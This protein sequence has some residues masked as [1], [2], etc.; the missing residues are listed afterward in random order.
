MAREVPP[1]GKWVAVT[2]SLR[3]KDV[4]RLD[5]VRGDLNRSQWGRGVILAA[6]E[7]PAQAALAAFGA[8]LP[9]SREE[10]VKRP[11]KRK[12]PQRPG[13]SPGEP[14]PPLALHEPP[15]SPAAEV[16]SQPSWMS[17]VPGR[18]A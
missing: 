2:V 8:A 18:R 10:P 13:E 16:P 7:N 11:R 12:A 14:A 9:E 1:E 6:L 17:A 3:A 4:E 5:A 15:P